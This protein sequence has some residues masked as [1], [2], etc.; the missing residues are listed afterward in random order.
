MSGGAIGGVFS[1]IGNAFSGIVKGIGSTVKN[2]LRDPLPIIEMVAITYMTGGLGAMAAEGMLGADAIG[3]AAVGD[4]A[5][6]AAIET[7]VPAALSSAAVTAINGGNVSQIATAGITAGLTAGMASGLNATQ[8][9]QHMTEGMDPAMARTLASASGQSVGGAI[10]AI[11]QGRDPL[12]GAVSGA[13]SG[14]LSS[15]LSNGQI[16]DLNKASASIIG[17]SGGAG[18][19]TALSGGNAEQVGQAVSNSLINASAKSALSDAYGTVK[20][21][22]KDVQ[23][24]L[25]KYYD[26]QKQASDAQTAVQAEYANV[27]EKNTAAQNIADKLDA[28]ATAYKTAE[29]NYN[30]NKDGGDA[31][32]LQAQ[33][34]AMDSAAKNYEAL[35]PQYDETYRALQDVA[36]PL[37]YHV[38]QLN[39]LQT[40]L[41]SISDTA[42]KQNAS[43]VTAGNSLQ[44]QYDTYVNNLNTEDKSTAGIQARVDAMSPEAQAAYKE[45]LASGAN[46]TDGLAAASKVQAQVAPE[47]THTTIDPFAVADNA[48][49][50]DSVQQILDAFNKNTTPS[51]PGVQVASAD[52]GIVSDSNSAPIGVDV[53]GT[54][55]YAGDPRGSSLKLPS[56]FSLMPM[57]LNE[58]DDSGNWL[59]PEGAYYDEAQNAWLMPGNDTGTAPVNAIL[60]DPNAITGNLPTAT[61]NQASTTVTPSTL[62]QVAKTNQAALTAAL[63]SNNSDLVN[64]VRTNN[65]EVIAALAN[66]DITKATSLI[67]GPSTSSVPSVGT[68]TQVPTVP[69]IG[70]DGTSNSFN[71]TGNPPAP[72]NEPVG[73]PA[74]SDVPAPAPTDTATSPTGYTGNVAIPISAGSGTGSS[75][76]I[77]SI[78]A[79]V[80]TAAAA[81]GTTGKSGYMDPTLDYT[82]HLTHGSK[83]DLTGVPTYNPVYTTTA[84]A[85]PQNAQNPMHFQ[86]GGLAQGYAEGS[87]VSFDPRI[88]RGHPQLLQHFT[89]NIPHPT[90]RPTLGMVPFE[91]HSEGHSVGQE[92][93]NPEFYSEGGL[94]SMDHTYVTGDG[95]GTSDSIPAMLA[96]GEFVI[97]ADVVASL[98]NGSNDS[99]AKVLDEFMKTIRE[100]K[101]DA[102]AEHLPPDSKG[103]LAYLNEAKKKVQ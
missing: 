36:D 76:Q 2:I 92:E 29:T 35:K 53:G 21:L 52:T 78:G 9:L 63:A 11:L 30:N 10:S 34:D 54:P 14:A 70:P 4:A 33:V 44:N 58:K 57:G 43:L 46:A 64:A 42:A 77:P 40:E 82:A 75:S 8:V 87:E 65:P 83:I 72:V 39:D 5:A 16:A 31:T 100:H 93:H 19:A 94:K 51:G 102:N 41:K 28:S 97:P 13:V 91:H 90:G 62:D 25:T 7:A 103:A 26:T 84:E 37:K 66:N 12:T 55:I 69:S 86:A 74:P 59:R 98:G 71:V 24:T 49:T 56:G 60:A 15:S 1:S 79:G 96:N 61:A 48:G 45:A 18:T 38:S 3:A 50:P 73:P 20:G 68:S 23:N 89:S 32:Y 81:A 95:D 67:G 6:Y 88:T 80:G 47:G 27:I 99:G 101:R 17:A 22:S 85:N